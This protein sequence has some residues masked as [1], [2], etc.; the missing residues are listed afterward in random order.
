MAKF[1]CVNQETCISCGS[2]GAIAPDVFEY[3]DS[4]L[5]YVHLDNNEGSAEVPDVFH[6]DVDD[7]CEECPTGSIKVAAEPILVDQQS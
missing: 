6:D 4:G 7:A 1:V 2:C 3:D 5:A